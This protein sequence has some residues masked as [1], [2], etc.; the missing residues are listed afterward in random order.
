MYSTAIH[1]ARR[2]FKGKKNRSN[3]KEHVQ[4]SPKPNID[5]Q[6]TVNSIPGNIQKLFSA[7]L[8]Y[9]TTGPGEPARGDK[10]LDSF[11]PQMETCDIHSGE[12]RLAQVIEARRGC[13]WIKELVVLQGPAGKKTRA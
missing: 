3:L 11:S 4:H 13:W 7:G 2:S 6:Y 9:G 10:L 8:G 12:A 1:K 5:T